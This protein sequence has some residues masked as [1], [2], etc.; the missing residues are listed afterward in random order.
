MR[1]S[2][3]AKFLMDFCSREGKNDYREK[4]RDSTGGSGVPP[5]IRFRRR[6]SIAP[7]GALSSASFSEINCKPNEILRFCSFDNTQSR[8]QNICFVPAFIFERDNDARFGF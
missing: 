2:K 6:P 5:D 1:A 7:N 4:N 3:A 8:F